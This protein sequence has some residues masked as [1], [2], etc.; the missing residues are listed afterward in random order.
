MSNKNSNKAVAKYYRS[1]PLVL[2]AIQYNGKNYDEIKKFLGYSP[3]I[4]SGEGIYIT[5]TM[6]A[7]DLPILDIVKVGDYIIKD[8]K[9][10]CGVP[11]ANFEEGYEEI[12]DS[13]ADLYVEI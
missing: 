9:G 6:Y 7:T 2:K 11:K 8:E 5:A 4:V 1:V 13:T 3:D 12:P 10:I